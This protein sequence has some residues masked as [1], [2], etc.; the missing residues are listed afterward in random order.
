MNFQNFD[1]SLAIISFNLL[2]LIFLSP[3]NLIEAILDSFPLSIS[4]I[5]STLLSSIFFTLA[6]T[7]EKLNPIEE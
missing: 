6:S 4:I 5:K 2:S 7:L 1:S 3:I